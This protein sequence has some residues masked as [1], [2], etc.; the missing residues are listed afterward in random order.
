MEEYNENELQYLQMMQ[1]NITR[2]ASME[3]LMQEHA[4]RQ[5]TIARLTRQLAETTEQL[6]VSDQ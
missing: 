5:K 2:M 6:V 1:E 3:R 4:D